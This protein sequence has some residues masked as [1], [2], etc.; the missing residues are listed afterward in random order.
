MKNYLRLLLAIVSFGYVLNVAQAETLADI[1]RKT[2]L[3][4]IDFKVVQLGVP[5]DIDLEI[6][7]NIFQ[8]H[9]A[10][11]KLE[12]SNLIDF[13]S[14]HETVLFSGHEKVF[15][16]GHGTAFFIAPN[17]VV[18][19]FH[20][21]DDRYESNDINKIMYLTQEGRRYPIAISKILYASAWADLVILET[22]EEV[23]EY[24]NLSE[25]SEVSEEE[26]SGMM[27]LLDCFKLNRSQ[28][29][30]LGRLFAL[31]YPQGVK[32]TWIH[33]GEYGVIDSGYDYEMAI[34]EID[35]EALSGVSV[36]GKK[37]EVV[38]GISGGPVLND[39]TEMI[40][41]IHSTHRYK[42]ILNVI[43]ASKLEELRRGS[44][45]LDCSN[46]T[47]KECIY[48]EIKNL[49]EKAEEGDLRSKFLLFKM[50]ITGLGA[51]EG[52]IREGLKWLFKTLPCLP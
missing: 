7:E 38:N 23:S 34:H 32:S 41:V 29:D 13:L 14:G 9:K 3:N 26:S 17:Q 49:K 40:G 10:V 6:P 36:L 22:E 25:V 27:G 51:V 39:K 21:I 35:S 44:I 1:E 42:N 18:T 20:V 5:E 15:F 52:D 37:K 31:G 47:L 16:S 12:Y 33:S 48:Q 24:L 28:E 19:N 2:R 45:G 50:Y 4:Q 46:L 30:S 11:W 43:K 8:A